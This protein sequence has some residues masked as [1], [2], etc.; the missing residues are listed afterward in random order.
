MTFTPAPATIPHLHMG[1][2][3]GSASP[4]LFIHLGHTYN[5]TFGGAAFTLV[6]MLVVASTGSTSFTTNTGLLVTVPAVSGT[7]VFPV[8]F[9]GTLA[10]WNISS[11]N[12]TIDNLVFNRAVGVPELTSLMLL[13]VGLLGLGLLR[14]R[15][16]QRI[17]RVRTF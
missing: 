9:T 17:S 16:V 14:R 11:G 15:G 5:M 13:A 8:A 1:T 4:N 6:S 3:S 2:Q 7:F 10:S 12:M